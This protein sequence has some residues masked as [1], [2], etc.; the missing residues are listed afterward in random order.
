MVTYSVNN[1]YTTLGVPHEATT[2]EIEAAWR[3]A[4]KQWHPDHNRSEEATTRLREI[5]LARSVLMDAI[6]RKRYDRRIGK[7]STVSTA[8]E[9]MQPPLRQAA[10][11]TNAGSTGGLGI[12]T[13]PSATRSKR[14]RGDDGG[15]YEPFAV[16]SNI[17]WWNRFAEVA[18]ANAEK[19]RA[20]ASIAAAERDRAQ[21]SNIVDR[22]PWVTR[23]VLIPAGV[24]AII[25]AASLTIM[26]V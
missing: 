6:E 23:Y 13:R 14:S 10:T 18:R 19:T 7:S 4:V 2:S 24:L 5:H 8:S 1:H 26:L 21:I 25:I 20:E 9:R 12:A 11:I 16:N 3:R 22:R 17:D 15:R